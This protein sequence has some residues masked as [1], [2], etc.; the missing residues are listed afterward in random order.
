MAER[1]Q[2]NASPTSQSRNTGSAAPTTFCSV[3]TRAGT[4]GVRAIQARRQILAV[5][6]QPTWA[7]LGMAR[8]ARRLRQAGAAPNVG[9]FHRPTV[10]LAPLARRRAH[11]NRP[12]GVESPG[13]RHHTAA[14]VIPLPLRAVPSD[15]QHGGRI[16]HAGSPA[17]QHRVPGP[18]CGQPEP[19]IPGG[20]GAP[21]VPGSLPVISPSSLR[22]CDP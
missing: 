6:D 9:E 7:V 19:L 13:R 16:P 10:A 2:G 15:R 3:R 17:A 14:G 12:R 8:D 5:G 4:C 18:G 22:N 21:S 1:W 20:R 11:R